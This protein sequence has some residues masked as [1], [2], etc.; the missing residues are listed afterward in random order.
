M[1]KLFRK[2]EQ[3]TPKTEQDEELSLRE[4]DDKKFERYSNNLQGSRPL[5]AKILEK[6]LG[7]NS[8]R[9]QGRPTSAKRHYVYPVSKVSK[10]QNEN[11]LLS[12]LRPT[13]ITMDK[14][15]LY[16]ENMAL[17][18]ENN[19]LKAENM[20]IR[21][22]LSQADK[23]LTKKDEI[24]EELNNHER[25]PGHK[26]IRLVSSLK[27]NIKEIKQDIKN[28]EEELQKLRKNLRSSK[29]NELEIEIQTYVDE[30]V[31][32]KHSMEELMKRKGQDTLQSISEDTKYQNHII[33]NLKREKQDLIIT[34]SNLQEE[35]AKFK[36]KLIDIEKGKKKNGKK[37]INNALK[38]EIQKLKMQIENNLKEIKEKDSDYQNEMI[39]MKKNYD[40][41][42]IKLEFEEKK[43][44]ELKKEIENLNSRSVRVSENAF[45]SNASPPP[46]QKIAEKP[47]EIIIIPTFFYKLHEILESKNMMITVFISLLDK[48]QNGFIEIDELLNGMKKYGKD[49]QKKDIEDLI[50][51]KHGKLIISLSKLVTA[52]SNYNFSNPENK[53]PESEELL[54]I[55]PKGSKVPTFQL[56]QSPQQK[57]IPLIK[58]L[59]ILAYLKHIAFCMQ[60]H[61]LSKLDLSST[62]FGKKI[63]ADQLLS[64]EQLAL[65]FK[66]PPFVF[67]QK[68]NIDKLCEFLVQPKGE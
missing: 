32:L 65:Y 6:R 57:K 14:E 33:S 41:V 15:R 27:Q 2:L 43:S 35:N 24:I 53:K 7:I 28:K 8:R 9:K 12:R 22:R 45:V 26:Y 13:L 52:Y 34:I 36:E 42:R 64:K 58:E 40:D 4:T 63:Q 20:R 25:S 62:M 44:R 23:E 3:K 59:E 30:C 1:Y 48:N 68:N 67:I 61:R 21:T 51:S 5:S 60:L 17:K 38:L 54:P 11:H 19:G 49:I 50:E 55:P 46:K 16:E 56:D 47:K 39:S 66:N 18:L 29:L 31:R 10:V 37:D